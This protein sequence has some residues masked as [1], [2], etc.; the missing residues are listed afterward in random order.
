MNNVTAK[1]LLGEYL[2]L[3]QEIRSSHGMGRDKFDVI[4]SRKHEIVSKLL[5]SDDEKL[6]DIALKLQLDRHSSNAC[7]LIRRWLGV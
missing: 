1:E 3:E 5:S 6:L 2:S 4:N 7:H